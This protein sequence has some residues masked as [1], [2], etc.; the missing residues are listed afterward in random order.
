MNI[1]TGFPLKAESG[2]PN[3]RDEFP[4]SGRFHVRVTVITLSIERR[5]S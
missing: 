1:V 2:R 5:P 3:S 4:E